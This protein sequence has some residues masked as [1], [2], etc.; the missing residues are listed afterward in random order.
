MSLTCND[1]EEE[2]YDLSGEIE[3]ERQENFLHECAM[4]DMRDGIDPNPTN[5]DSDDNDDNE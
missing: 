3:E 5:W 1:G 4:R 2:P